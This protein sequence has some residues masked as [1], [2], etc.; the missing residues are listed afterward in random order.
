MSINWRV[1]LRHRSFWLGLTGALGT[2]AMALAG[3]SGHS[4]HAAPIVE[5][6]QGLLTSALAVLALL[7]VVVDPTTEG[8]EDSDQAMSYEEPRPRK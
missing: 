4:E 2:F 7:G 3:L 6:A 8:T 5:S 1:R